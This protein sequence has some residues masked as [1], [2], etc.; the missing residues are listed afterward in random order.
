MFESHTKDNSEII[1]LNDGT[2][3]L[4]DHVLR[5]DG[6]IVSNSGSWRGTGRRIT[7]DDMQMFCEFHNK[8]CRI[9]D[10]GKGIVSILFP[11]SKPEFSCKFHFLT[12]HAFRRFT[13][14]GDEVFDTWH[15]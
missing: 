14:H 6:K 13:D 1:Q 4:F 12:V 7:C 9:T 15:P 11:N 3:M 8:D 5:N 10:V 2:F